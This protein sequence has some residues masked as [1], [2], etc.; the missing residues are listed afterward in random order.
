MTVISEKS[1]LTFGLAILLP[2]TLA[3]CGNSGSGSALK[4]SAQLTPPPLQENKETALVVPSNKTSEDAKKRSEL[5][6]KTANKEAKQPIINAKAKMPPMPVRRPYRKMRKKSVARMITDKKTSA[7]RAKKVMAKAVVKPKIQTRVVPVVTPTII[8][9]AP[10][11][12][13]V[14][15]QAVK[16]QVVPEETAD[17]IFSGFIDG[18]GVNASHEVSADEVRAAKMAQAET[19]AKKPSFGQSE[20]RFSSQK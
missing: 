13:M 3:A 9:K 15:S 14:P 6:S 11:A 10:K 20:F 1:F 8:A 12:E 16:A 19:V 17:L 4:N 2:L 5:A 7:D 18:S